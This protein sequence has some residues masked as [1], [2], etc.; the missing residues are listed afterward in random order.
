MCNKEFKSLTK[1]CICFVFFKYI[2]IDIMSI[3]IHFNV[4]HVKDRYHDSDIVNVLI[5]FEIVLILG[6]ILYF[7]LKNVAI[8]AAV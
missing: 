6:V 1:Q 5:T 8:F 4:A 3:L 2:C 7:F